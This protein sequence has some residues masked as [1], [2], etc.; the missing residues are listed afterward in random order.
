MVLDFIKLLQKNERLIRTIKHIL[1]EF[2]E[3]VIIRDKANQKV[4]FINKTAENDFGNKNFNNVM[5][6]CTKD[7][8]EDYNERTNRTLQ[9]AL[10]DA[11]D[12][13]SFNI[14]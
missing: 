7:S 12:Q 6:Y 1:E 13:L 3:G 10:E 9:K 8:F 5:V 2:P 14:A 11:E 4:Q